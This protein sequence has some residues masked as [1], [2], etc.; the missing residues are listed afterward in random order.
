MNRRR[1]ILG[2]GVAVITVITGCTGVE[3]DGESEETEE[4]NDSESRPIPG[5]GID[6][7]DDI[8][9]GDTVRIR[10]DIRTDDP[11]D[12]LSDEEFHRISEDIVEDRTNEQDVN[13]IVI[14][15][16]EDT[17]QIGVE[18]AYARMEWAPDGDLGAAHT[19]STGDYS[20]HEY[21]LEYLGF[22]Q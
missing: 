20:E 1:A 19:V 3:E 14:F 7:I 21:E 5:Y 13:A 9:S 2:T 18:T 15:F 8:S 4:E 17:A 16:W 12:E 6:Q 11:V 22:D 10:M